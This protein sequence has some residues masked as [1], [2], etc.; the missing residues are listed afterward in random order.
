MAL[1]K[2]IASILP[3]VERWKADKNL[4]LEIR[5]GY[6]MGAF[7]SNVDQEF[8]QRVKNAVK[9]SSQMEIKEKR[10]VSAYYKHPS[11]LESGSVRVRF[12][13]YGQPQCC[14]VTPAEKMS[15]KSN[16]RQYSLQT[17]IM[18]ETTITYDYHRNTADYICLQTRVDAIYKDWTYSFT[19]IRRG[20]DNEDAT[21]NKPVYSIEI[22]PGDS[23]RAYS[24]SETAR[25]IVQRGAQLLGTHLNGERHE[26]QFSY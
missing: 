11:P 22:S 7:Y 13:Q 5:L 26:I 19:T 15:I 2:Y 17:S 20:K 8:Y 6:F 3:L 16:N 25:L 9:E 18:D 12:Y 21:Q 14:V 4:V 1:E 10:F 24:A 23:V